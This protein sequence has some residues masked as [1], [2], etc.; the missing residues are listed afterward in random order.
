MAPRSVRT[1]RGRKGSTSAY[2]QGAFEQYIAVAKVMRPGRDV[3]EAALFLMSD[4]GLPTCEKLCHQSLD[5]LLEDA[6]ATADPLEAA[7]WLFADAQ[8]DREFVPLARYLENNARS[9]SLIDAGTGQQLDPAAVVEGAMINGLAAMFGRQFP[10]DQ[11]IS[12]VAAAY[13]FIEPG[14]SDEERA[15]RE[16][17]VDASYDDVFNFEA[18]RVTAARVRPEK[19]QAAI[20]QFSSD[21]ENLPPDLLELLPKKIRTF[22][23]VLIGLALVAIDD[24]G[25]TEWFERATAASP[26]SL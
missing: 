6:E 7:E 26:P 15:A 22:M 3:R 12:E 9:A 21:S 4:G 24:L 2:P 8:R 23:P 20:R 18:L 19:L 11:A 25:G 10:T 16:R 14:L 1:S 5:Y 17:F 13:G